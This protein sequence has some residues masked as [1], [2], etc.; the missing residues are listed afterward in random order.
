MS[1]RLLRYLA[2]C[3]FNMQKYKTMYDKILIKLLL[4][5]VIQKENVIVDILN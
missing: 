3:H 4:N 5:H 1:G 2:L